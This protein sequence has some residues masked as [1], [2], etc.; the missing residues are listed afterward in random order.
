MHRASPQVGFHAMVLNWHAC[1]LSL[2]GIV[3]TSNALYMMVS[4]QNVFV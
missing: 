1:I 3:V 2:V 4:L